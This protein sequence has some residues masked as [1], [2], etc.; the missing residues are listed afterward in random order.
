MLS[1]QFCQNKQVP[2]KQFNILNVGQIT[3]INLERDFKQSWK[4]KNRIIYEVK[5]IQYI[6]QY[7]IVN[8]KTKLQIALGFVQRKGELIYRVVQKPSIFEET[9][10]TKIIKFSAQ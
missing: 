7:E 9:M 1:Q 2:G 8:L 4:K 10:G 3:Y 6:E 5:C